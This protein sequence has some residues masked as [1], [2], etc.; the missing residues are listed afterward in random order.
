[1]INLKFKGKRMKLNKLMFSTLLLLSVSSI[2]SAHDQ[3]WYIG[4]GLGRANADISSRDIVGSPPVSGPGKGGKLFAGY[5]V[6]PNLAVEAGYLAFGSVRANGPTPSTNGKIK[7]KALNLNA[8]ASLPFNDVFALAAKAG[9]FNSRISKSGNLSYT[10]RTPSNNTGLDYGFGAQVNINENVALQAAYD[11][12]INRG[13]NR[14]R[15]DNN[16]LSGNLVYNFM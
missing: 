11:K 14:L 4:G 2:T 8:V 1:M 7:T 15:M 9:V 3:G 6:N 10:G 5:Q 12:L 13:S 16:L